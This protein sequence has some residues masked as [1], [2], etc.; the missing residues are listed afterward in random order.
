MSDRDC[1][2]I[3]APDAELLLWPQAFADIAAAALDE[4]IAGLDWHCETVRMFGREHRA[5]RLTAFYGE[6]GIVYRY[7]G[8]DHEAPGWPPLLA[9][10]RGRVEALTANAFNCVLANCYRNGDDRMGY[11]RDDE[12]ELGRNPAIASVSFGAVRTFA[13]RR[14]DRRERLDIELADGSLLLMAGP[15][16]HHWQHALPPRRRVV[17]PRVNLT[18]RRVLQSA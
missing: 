18:F 8:T 10:I 11:H 16:Q 4:L 12:P 14:R 13:L 3:D 7:S 6:P 2:R 1:Q 9:H 17:A 5:R 15:T